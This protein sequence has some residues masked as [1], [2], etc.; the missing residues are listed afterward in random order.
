M[1]PRKF[2]SFTYSKVDSKVIFESNLYKF[3][4]RLSDCNL[5]RLM[6]MAVEGLELSSVPFDE[7]LDVFKE[8]NRRIEL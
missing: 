7:I 5:S 4:N 2:L 1:P 3:R 6:K 8:T